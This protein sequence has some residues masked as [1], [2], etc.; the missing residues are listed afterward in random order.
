MKSFKGYLRWL[1]EALEYKGQKAHK[2]AVDLVAQI[3]DQIGSINGEVSKDVRKGKTTSNRLGVQI[4]LSA[5]KRIAFTSLANAA[6]KQDKDLEFDR[7][8]P[9]KSRAKKD[10]AFRHKDIKETIYV[11]TRPDGKRGGGA[12]ADPNEL[13]TAALCTLS[14]VPKVTAVEDLDRLILQ[15][16]DIV[17]SGK[18]KGYSSLEV[19]ALEQSYGN[20]CMAISAANVII[21]KGGGSADMVYLTGKAWDDD[22]TQFQVT[23]FGMRDFNASDFI[24]KKGKNF[25]GISLKKKKSLATADPTMINKGFSTM[26]QGDEFKTVREELDDAAGEFYVDVVRLAQR[27]QRAKPLEAVDKDGN[28]FLDEN[29]LE[30]LGPKGEGITTKNWKEFVQRIPNDLINI[31]LRKSKSLFKPIS[32]IVTDNA[33]LF[34][35]Q[36]LQLILKTD[37]KELKK[38][39][40]DFALVIGIGRFTPRGGPI[41]EKGEYDSI[42]IMV[43]KLDDLL[44]TGSVSLVED[45]SQTQ[46]YQQGATAAMLWF[47]LSIGKTPICN[48]TLRYKGNFRAA[49]NFLATMTPEFKEILSS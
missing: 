28:P 49:P 14:K 5:A 4:I 40:F 2:F 11:V 26:I 23:K 46:A 10:F 47:V 18:I 38:V 24:I 9:S 33:D 19:V 48:I 41:I 39:N 25:I 43:T 1:I 3:D 17:K 44:A 36:L 20:L 32:K 29:D 8:S 45:S 42:D 13:M 34:G 22:V 16:K 7:S 21:A 15:V 6:I 30:D 27:F 37:L 12:T 35:N 31:Q